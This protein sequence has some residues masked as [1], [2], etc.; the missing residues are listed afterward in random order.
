MLP[1]SWVATSSVW[2]RERA[3]KTEPAALAAFALACGCL[4]GAAAGDEPGYNIW[5]AGQIVS[6]DVQHGTLRIARGP[7]E[8]A[9]PGIETCTMIRKSIRR[10]RDGMEVEAEA[11]TRRRPWHILHMRVFVIKASRKASFRRTVA[12]RVIST[13][14]NELSGT[15]S[16]PGP[17]SARLLSL[18]HTLG[19]MSRSGLRAQTSHR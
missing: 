18:P 13:G 16:R 3:L 4:A 1:W 2:G 19:A 10:L 5:F 17:S 8:T 11:D 14:L 7:T 6:R 12:M 9:G 15:I